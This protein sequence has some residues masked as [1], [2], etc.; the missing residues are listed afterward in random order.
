MS[1]QQGFLSRYV[2]STDH[3]VIA[4][5]YLFTGIFW[6]LAGGLMALLI[7]W[8]LAN[9]FQPI[10]FVGK[11]FFGGKGI[12]SPDQYNM[13]F[14][15]H[16]SIMVFFA[17]T[18]MVLGAFGNFVIPLQI[19]ARDMAFPKLNMLSY[20]LVVPASVIMIASFFAIGGGRAGGWTSYPPLASCV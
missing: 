19:G 18:P 14:T 6:L 16:G 13:L 3:K 12:M 15:M 1:G 2:F 10:P 17:I 9:P 7:R 4:K 20:W 11:F 8:Q 5:Q